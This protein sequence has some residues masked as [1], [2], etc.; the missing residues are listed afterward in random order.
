MTDLGKLGSVNPKSMSEEWKQQWAEVHEKTFVSADSTEIP[1]EGRSYRVTKKIAPCP[2]CGSTYG[3]VIQHQKN[4]IR[5]ALNTDPGPHV[6]RC[7]LCGA[8]GPPSGF[9]LR[10]CD[11][12]RAWNCHVKPHPTRW[13]RL[14]WWLKR[15]YRKILP[16]KTS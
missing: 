4:A 16:S 11:I 9:G 2:F 10:I 14:G 6:A 13:E 7:I 3:I 8:W 5:F 1:F 12:I 15:Q